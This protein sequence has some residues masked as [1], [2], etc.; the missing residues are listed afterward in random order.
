MKAAFLLLALSLALAHALTRQE[1]EDKWRKFQIDFSKSYKSSIEARKRF[2]IFE[3]N[4]KKIE[5][6][7][8]RFQ[9]G[10]VSYTKGINK[11][12]DWTSEE[13]LDYVN[14]Y[15]VSKR[16][17]KDSETFKPKSNFSLPASVDWRV[18]G[19]ITGVKDQ[20]ICGSCWA[21]S[22]TGSLEAQLYLQKGK[23]ISLSEQNLIDC[24]WAE[25]N[26]GC[27]GGLMTSAW[28]YVQKNGCESEDDY[29]YEEVDA[30]C[31]FE[32]T[33]SVVSISGYVE[34]DKKE[35]DLQIAVASIGPISV[36]IDASEELQSYSSGILEDN[37]C[38]EYFL[39]HGVLLVGYGSE[40]GKDFYIIKNS[41]GAAWGEQGYFRLGKKGSNPCGITED[42]S[43]P[44]VI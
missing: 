16:P 28:E 39:N 26:E 25:G 32:Q 11:F 27:E 22:T 40:N 20:G 6:H 43:Y 31:R 19:C 8:I 10:E 24:S 37:S 1:L 34:I 21:F 44:K 29:P 7:N 5:E 15:K 36:G 14:Q 4:L 30:K 33:K 42:A 35:V 23:L 38:S 12:A 17:Q 2:L 41:W 3:D 9:N 13:F 18:Q